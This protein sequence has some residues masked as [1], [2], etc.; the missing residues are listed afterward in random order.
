LGCKLGV[1]QRKIRVRTCQKT[2]SN[3]LLSDFPEMW[4]VQKKRAKKE[5]SIIFEPSESNLMELVNHIR[6]LRKRWK[7]GKVALFREV[8]KEE[9]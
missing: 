5:K 4:G 7:G 2:S 3:E 9:A 6:F 8:R 1:T